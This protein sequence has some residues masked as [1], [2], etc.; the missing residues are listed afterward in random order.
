MTF[1]FLITLNLWNLRCII[2]KVIWICLKLVTKVLISF[3]YLSWDADLCESFWCYCISKFMLVT[4]NLHLMTEYYF[5][6]LLLYENFRL[7]QMIFEYF[8]SI[9]NV[10][11]TFHCDLWILIY[12]IVLIAK[13][14]FKILSHFV[15]KIGCR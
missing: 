8:H 11:S 13:D 4:Y 14:W 7:K 2:E 9:V 3:V 15:K 5:Y 1:G 10:S 6:Q 12:H